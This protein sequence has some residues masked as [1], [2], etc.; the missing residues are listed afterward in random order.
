MNINEI[1]GRQ[2]ASSNSFTFEQ[3][4]FHFP[5]NGT[6]GSEHSING[7]KRTAE[8]H[9][10]HFN[11]KYQNYTEATKYKDGV[12]GLNIMLNLTSQD[13]ENLKPITEHLID[14]QKINASIPLSGISLKSFLPSDSSVFYVYSGSRTTPLCEEIVTKVVFANSIGISQTQLNYFQSLMLEAPGFPTSRTTQPLNGRTIYAST[15][16]QCSQ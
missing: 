5:A 14:I 2:A 10:I 6:Q 3:F 12:L 8:L 7:T 11:S 9:L 16:D 15:N 4:H 1:L 13:N